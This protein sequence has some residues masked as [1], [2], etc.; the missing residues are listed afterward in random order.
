MSAPAIALLPKC[1]PDLGPVTHLAKEVCLRN[2]HDK[3]ALRTLFNYHWDTGGQRTRASLALQTSI[4]LELDHESSIAMATAVEL[5]H[6]AS[7][8]QDDMQDQSVLRRKKEAVWK[9]FGTNAALALTDLLISGAYASLGEVKIVKAIP[10]L[11]RHT[12]RNVSFTIQGQEADLGVSHKNLEALLQA[13]RNKSGFLFA[14]GVELP[15]L[16]AG[17]S[18]FI[19]LARDAASSF[20]IGYQIYDDLLDMG[21]DRRA[22]G[23]SNIVLLLEKSMTRMAARNRAFWM[24]HHYLKM[25]KGKALELP[26][27][28]GVGLRQL[29]VTLEHRL[30][31]L[32]Q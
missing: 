28:S 10:S 21:N 26:Q 16:C 15:L 3:S 29:V 7:L 6:N 18:E 17:R 25:A 32:T 24:A 22:L 11:L 1:N 5:L 9:R 12:H 14:L 2:C 27:N 8:V 13:A 19:S 20:G 23:G 30:S 31:S 4:S